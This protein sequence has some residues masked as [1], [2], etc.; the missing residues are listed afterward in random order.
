MTPPPLAKLPCTKVDA[1]EDEA[2]T[3]GPG[4]GPCSC[5][6]ASDEDKG[7][8][9]EEMDVEEMADCAM[10]A[11]AAAAAADMELAKAF[12]MTLMRFPPVALSHC[13]FSRASCTY[14]I[15]GGIAMLKGVSYLYSRVCNRGIRERVIGVSRVDMWLFF[16]PLALVEPATPDSRPDVDAGRGLAARSR[17]ALAPCRRT[18]PRTRRLGLAPTR[19]G[20]ST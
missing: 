9:E 20:G 18:P 19:R 4:P 3:P 16:I 14:T 15:G 6:Y 5:W 2:P 1:W 10:A 11:S 13:C 7:V 17:S 8:T 12:A